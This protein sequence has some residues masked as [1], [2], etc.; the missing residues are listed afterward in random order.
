MDKIELLI[1]SIN[2]LSISIRNITSFLSKNDDETINRNP[3]SE[4]CSCLV[5]ENDGIPERPEVTHEQLDRELDRY[6]YVQQ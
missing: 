5:C 4:D 1:S 2:N 3:H 6:F